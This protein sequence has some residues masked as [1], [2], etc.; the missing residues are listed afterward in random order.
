M[1]MSAGTFI[2]TVTVRLG[3]MEE[4]LGL[5]GA[6]IFVFVCAAEGSGEDGVLPGVDFCSLLAAPSSQPYSEENN[7]RPE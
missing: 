4:L 1:Q 2:S 3:K 6:S 7:L 5:L